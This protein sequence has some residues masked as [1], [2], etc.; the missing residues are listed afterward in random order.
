[1]GLHELRTCF[2]N[3]KP[4]N[5]NGLRGLCFLLRTKYRTLKG[6]AIHRIITSIYRVIVYNRVIILL[7][8]NIYI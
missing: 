4:S 3:N 5:N 7:L 1:M 8:Y 6:F 2:N